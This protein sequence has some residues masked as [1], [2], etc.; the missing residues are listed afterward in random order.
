MKK[1]LTFT[2]IL[3]LACLL[4]LPGMASASTLNFEMGDI[5]TA[6]VYMFKLF[7][8]EFDVDAVQGSLTQLGSWTYQKTPTTVQV[9][10]FMSMFGTKTP[11]AGPFLAMDVNIDVSTAP[12]SLASFEFGSYTSG[13]YYDLDFIYTYDSVSTTGTYQFNTASAVPLP[14]AAWLLGSGLVGL[15]G[16]RRRNA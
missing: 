1:K 15:L 8:T 2:K 3:L 9:Y 7:G 5:G 16:L 4:A 13:E 10:D 6:E 14:G 12:Y 11:V